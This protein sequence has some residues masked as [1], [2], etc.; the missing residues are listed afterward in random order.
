MERFGVRHYS[1][2]LAEGSDWYWQ[3]GWS[4][5]AWDA[6][7]YERNKSWKLWCSCAKPVQAETVQQHYLVREV[8]FPLYMFVFFTTL[9]QFENVVNW[10]THYD[11]FSLWIL[12][13]TRIQIVWFIFCVY[14]YI[15]FCV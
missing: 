1:L 3:L 10:T 9:C 2:L 5:H 13:D 4:S 15:S 14:L 12:V 8:V 6:C 7:W 11:S